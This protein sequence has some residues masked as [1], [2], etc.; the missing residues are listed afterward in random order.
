MSHNV[1]LHIERLVLDAGVVPAQQRGQVKAAVEQEL[2][3]LL[4]QDGLPPGLEVARAV[5][6]VAALPIE[7]QRNRQPRDVGAQ[8]ARSVYQGISR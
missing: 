1:H 7:L 8:I 5:R 2:S 3:R 6:S 4:S